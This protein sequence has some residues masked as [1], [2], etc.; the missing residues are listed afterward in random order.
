MDTDFVTGKTEPNQLY[1]GLPTFMG[2]PHRTDAVGAKV[3]IL[4]CPFDCGTHPFR[5]GARQGPSSIRE[6]SKLIFRY[7]SELADVDVLDMLGAVDCGDV[8]LTPSRAE[9][10]F[11]AIEEAAFRIV[12]GGAVPIGLGG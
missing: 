11:I 8:R 12:S 7:H 6:Q 2:I 3:A 5:V 1:D 9:E 4:G 10:S